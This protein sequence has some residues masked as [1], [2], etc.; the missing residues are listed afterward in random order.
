[1]T[2]HTSLTGSDFIFTGE[3]VPSKA[4]CTTMEHPP[5][6]PNLVRADFFPLFPRLKLALK[7]QRFKDAEN[8]ITN[9]TIQLKKE[10]KN[11]FHECFQQ[12]YAR[13]QKCVAEG[14]YFE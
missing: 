6:S 2:P 7:G 1:M 10:S 9:A 8:I 13:W 5:Y 14:N 3:A 4:K 12:L 11:Q